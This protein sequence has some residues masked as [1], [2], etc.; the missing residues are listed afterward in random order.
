[1]AE[2]TPVFARIEV[3]SEGENEAPRKAVKGKKKISQS[4]GLVEA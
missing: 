1:M 3:T 4:Q 2:P